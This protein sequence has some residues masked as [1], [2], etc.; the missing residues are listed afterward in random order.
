[1]PAVGGATNMKSTEPGWKTV[2]SMHR[3]ESCVAAFIDGGAFHVHCVQVA[4]SA[5]HFA[6]HFQ[7]FQSNRRCQA[8]KQPKRDSLHSLDKHHELLILGAVFCNLSRSC[9]NLYMIQ[10]VSHF[11][12]EDGWA[13]KIRGAQI[14]CL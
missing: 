13:Q 1:M 5:K 9:V 4:D 10:L 6:S 2:F 8:T 12:K 11:R 14:F 3:V 7:P